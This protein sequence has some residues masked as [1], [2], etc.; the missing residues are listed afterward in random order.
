MTEPV[1]AI[2]ERTEGQATRE[3]RRA[4][5]W[6]RNAFRVAAVMGIVAITVFFT[7]LA[8]RDVRYGE[9]WAALKRSNYWWLFPTLAALAVHVVLRV[10]RW[11]LVFKPDRRPPFDPTAKATL[12]GYLFNSILP[13]RAGEAARIVALNEYAG[14]SR[15]EATATVVV[16]RVFDVLSLLVI[17]FVMTPWLPHVSWLRSAALLALVLA[18]A[19]AVAIA[20]I[21]IYGERPVLFALRPLARLP[22]LDRNRVEHMARNV[23]HGLESLRNFRHGLAVFLCTT[24]SWVVLGVGFWF[25]MLGFDLHLSVLAGLLVTV[26]IGLSFIVPSPPAGV[27]IFEAAGLAALSSYGISKSHGLAYVLVLHVV[28]VLPLIAAGLLVLAVQAR[29]ARRLVRVRA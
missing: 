21:A 5:R 20:V 22:F 24:L 23:V 18:I 25:L 17:L 2:G 11:Q 1:S 13:A 15:A 9:T 10:F 29:R 8:L 4:S 27:G 28:N 19:F 3:Q 14:T 7:Y 16:E 12:V 26:A 6:R